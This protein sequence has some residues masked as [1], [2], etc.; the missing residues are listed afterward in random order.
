M[1]RTWC[2]ATGRRIA[3]PRTDILRA[4]CAAALAAVVFGSS[5]TGRA[6]LIVRGPDTAVPAVEDVSAVAQ[7]AP[8]A[9]VP[10]FLL[11]AAT[12]PAAARAQMTAEDAA[13]YTR[14]FALQ[15]TGDLDAADAEIRQLRDRRLMGHVERQR[16]LLPGRKASYDELAGWLARYADH[17]GA[18]RIHTLAVRRQPAGQK[19]PR[20][21][22]D[23]DR[24]QGSLERLA[25]ARPRS[26]EDEGDEDAIQSVA[27]SSRSGRGGGGVAVTGRIADLI[28]A[29]KPAAAL[30][31]LNDTQYSRHLETAQYDA[32]RARIAAA[33]YYGGDV[34]TALSLAGASAERSGDRVPLAHWIAGLA[35]WRLK[36]VEQ[37]DAHFTAMVRAAPSSPWQMAAAAF[38]AARMEVRL[39]RKAEARG[40]L[41]LAARYPHTFY[42]LLAGR[43]LGVA[44]P[45]RWDMP[46]LTG[47]HLA[48]LAAHPA[49][50]RAIGLLQAGRK[51]MAERELRRVHPRGD[52]LAAEALLLLGD[53]AG[54]PGLALQVGNAVS[55][56]DGA[57]YDAALFPLPYWTPR[58]G[59]SLDRALIFAV[60]R[61]ESRFDPTMVSPAGALGL[62]QIMPS[63]A[64]HVR[65][66]HDD[67]EGEDT[68]RSALFDTAINMDLG[69]RYLAELLAMPEVGNNLVHLAAAYNAGPGNALRWRR[70][71]LASVSDPLLYVESIPFAETRDYVHKVLANYWAYRMRLGQGLE[72]LDAVA[73][74][75]WPVYMP[76]DGRLAQGPQA[77]DK[78]VAQT[79]DN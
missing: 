20:S 30:A 14:I 45:L 63:T 66:R 8:V 72:S 47:R 28:A 13:R 64:Q 55:G 39:G 10:P 37:A 16:L 69:Q 71:T 9:A 35:S 46:D 59:F 18:E 44:A 50:A 38:W 11:L 67:I 79:P 4:A 48:A 33:L 53:R 32:A 6:A 58:N 29:G 51:D 77:L 52:R 42:G 41:Q 65:E 68:E 24:L 62:M 31:L 19:A 43:S 76:E 26:S 74:G 15:A 5:G 1:L 12:D 56:P 21:P 78:Q 49:G 17:A 54:L 22:V 23:V 70:E 75:R 25:G 57:P 73:A 36:Q 7:D 3:V 2:S 40:Y 27:P 34:R 61:Q 60:M